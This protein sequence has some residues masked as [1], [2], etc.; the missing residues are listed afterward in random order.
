MDTAAAAFD[1]VF[2]PFDDAETGTPEAVPQSLPR[3]QV[4]ANAFTEGTHDPRVNV[5]GRDRQATRE[6]DPT[7]QSGEREGLGSRDPS[8]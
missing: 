5:F 7:P 6:R 1:F 4:G 2:L 3:R 8:P